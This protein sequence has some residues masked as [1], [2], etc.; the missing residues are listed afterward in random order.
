MAASIDWI[1]EQCEAELTGLPDPSAEIQQHLSELGYLP[2]HAVTLTD[3]QLRDAR[4]AF[5]A[6]LERCGLFDVGELQTMRRL[7]RPFFLQKYL[8][9]LADIDEGVR[10]ERLPASGEKSLVTRMIHYRLDL[11]GLWEMPV[12]AAFGNGSVAAL[13][14]LAAFGKCSPLEALNDLSDIEQFT[15]RLLDVYRDEQ[16]IVTFRSAGSSDAMRQK[17]E[18]RNAFGRQLKADFGERTDYLKFL[19]KHVFN[20]REER[21]DYS[22]LASACHDDFNRFVIRLIQVHQWQEGFYSG[23][24][25]SDLTDL[26]L[27][28]FLDMIDA[29][30]EADSKDIRVKRFLTYLGQDY[31]MFNAL[32][33]L[34]EYMVEKS[35]GET[36]DVWVALSRQ[37]TQADD[38]SQ[39]RFSGS[40]SQLKDELSG[41]REPGQ[42]PG[43]FARIYYGV[44]KLLRKAFRF[45]SKIFRWVTEKLASVWTFLKKLFTDFFGNLAQGLRFFVNGLRFLLGRKIIATRSDNRLVVSQFSLDG[46]VRSIAI[47]VEAG[48][49]EQHL[50]E[51]RQTLGEMNFALAVTGQLLKIIMQS[52]S[53]ISWPFLLFS[54]VR[55]FRQISASFIQIKTI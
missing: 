24:L 37:V 48:L 1:V 47:N 41:G 51:T 50:D 30:N 2:W 32:F 15:V 28:S 31:F 17:L 43:F 23:L 3:R 53:L 36:D 21:I 12:D 11:M 8:R 20:D 26:G 7:G 9:R 19:Q 55:A 35:G 13:E 38:E 14:Q 40:L 45:A 33:F 10:L 4:E 52:L 54:I 39:R 25:D 29:Y 27:Q 22:F 42:R 18:H 44:R 46:D 16:F 34:K 49:V 5:E 6:D